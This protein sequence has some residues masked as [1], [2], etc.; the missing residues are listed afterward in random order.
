MY[1]ALADRVVG[2]L[3][4]LAAGDALGAG[5]E[6][7]A[8][9]TEPIEMKGGGRW[10]PGEWTDDTQMAICIAEVTATGTL[11]LEAVGDWF[12][13]WHRG[14]LKDV[15]VQTASVL[16]AARTGADLPRAA[17]AYFRAH[18]NGSA[19]NG[20]LMRTAPVALAH[21]GD[22]QAIVQVAREVSNLTHADPLAGDACVLWCIAIDRAVREGH[23]DGIWEGLDLLPPA[24]RDRWRGILDEAK[25]GPPGKFTRNGFVVTALQ[26]A[27]SAVWSTPMWEVQSCRHLQD[28][29]LAAV[30]I[31][32]DTDTVAAIAGSLLGARWGGTAVP[33]RWRRLL[34]GWPGYNARDLL[35]L[36]LLTAN[37]GSP[38][39]AG[40]PTGERMLPWYE[41]HNDLRHRAVPLHEVP[42]VLVGDVGGLTGR[43]GQA[44][45]VV[46]LCRMGT[47]EVPKG[48]E[49]QEIMLFDD[50]RPE[51][52]PNLDFM[53]GDLAW[54]IANRRAEGKAVFVHCVEAKHRTP[55]VAAA[56][57]ANHASVSGARALQMVRE[58][59]PSPPTHRVF[60]EALERQ[61]PDRR[62]AL[63]H[64][65][66]PTT[67]MV[68]SLSRGAC[69]GPCPVYEVSIS[70]TEAS[71]HGVQFCDRAGR[72]VANV[73]A[74]TFEEIAALV[75]EHGFFDWEDTYSGLT[76]HQPTYALEVVRG[77]QVKWVSQYA[78][79]EPEGFGII[80]TRLDE[81]AARLAWEPDPESWL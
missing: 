54:F 60:A 61:W 37:H 41:E 22:D 31:G 79:D 81:V 63:S 49:H 46:S 16:G 9:P 74:A 23:F 70:R 12:L 50:E 56:F 52:N 71:W 18:P 30:R 28:A 48:T 57:L 80:A 6:F 32:H 29:L 4:G 67:I 36:A 51:A 73:D 39:S 59:L 76:I 1:G 8:H 10:E 33:L 45:V 78:T 14:P 62:G 25:A 42:E 40:Y 69:F 55:A 17:A 15:G 34:H 65:S 53:L 21:L 68:V 75:E 38:D 35:R 26:A 77:G 2:T 13:E 47:A 66:E 20:S 44:D 24:S 64:G 19:G 43:G 11:D 3:V 5:Y 72:Y 7:Q 58:V 27:I